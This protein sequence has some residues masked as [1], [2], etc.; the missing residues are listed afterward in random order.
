MAQKATLVLYYSR[1]GH[2][3]AVA[4]AIAAQLDADLEP[5]IDE[6][7][8]SGVRGYLRS[9]IQAFF[10]QTPSLLPLLLDPAEYELVVVGSPVWNLSVSSPVRAFL[11]TQG[12][13]VRE[14]A[15][16]ASYA[17]L[18]ARR[19]LRQMEHASRLS[20]RATLA[21][22]ESELGAGKLGAIVEGFAAQL[23]PWVPRPSRPSRTSGPTRKVDRVSGLRGSSPSAG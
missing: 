12:R 1:S 16:F 17:T 13:R 4:E 9:G 11:E 3:R 15:F 23:A 20:P 7:D 10:E 8:R 2:T 19:A 6:L 21:V 22:R 18:G 14:V 5:L